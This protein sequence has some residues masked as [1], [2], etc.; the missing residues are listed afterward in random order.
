VP[1]TKAPKGSLV[2]I[3]IHLPKEVLK[4]IDELVRQGRYS[5]RA[6]LIRVAV[7]DILDEMRYQQHQQQQDPPDPQPDPPEDPPP[8]PAPKSKTEEERERSM[9]FRR[10]VERLFGMLLANLPQYRFNA[11]QDGTYKIP[12]KIIVRFFTDDCKAHKSTVIP[13]YNALVRAFMNAGFSVAETPH[14]FIIMKAPIEV[15]T[16]V[17]QNA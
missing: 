16:E 14:A 2:I 8:D 3:S 6:E 12:K 15:A 13:A 7:R 9:R 10:C 17:I 1:K 11:K 4:E 5:S